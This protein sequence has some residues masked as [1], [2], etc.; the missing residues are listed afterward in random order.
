MG[1]IRGL[2]G[3]ARRMNGERLGRVETHFLIDAL[4]LV[5]TAASAVLLGSLF[6]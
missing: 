3:L 2:W 6:V 1:R 4:A 5:L